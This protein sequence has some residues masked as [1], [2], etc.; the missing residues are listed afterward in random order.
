[1][2]AIQLVPGK[3][4][5]RIAKALGIP[6]GTERFVIECDVTQ[7]IRLYVKGCVQI[8]EYDALVD[9]LTIIPVADVTVA[10]DTTVHFVEAK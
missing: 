5:H 6:P 4:A 9:A 2:A 8:P 7:P 10:D 3:M 1:M